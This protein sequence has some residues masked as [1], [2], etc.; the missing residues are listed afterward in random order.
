MWI[1][2][3]IES[4]LIIPQQYGGVFAT[5]TTIQM[6]N[7][8]SYRRT[9]N[10]A[11]SSCFSSGGLAGNPKQLDSAHILIPTSSFLFQLHQKSSVSRVFLSLESLKLPYN[12]IESSGWNFNE[13]L[14]KLYKPSFIYFAWQ[15]PF[16]KNLQVRLYL[17]LDFEGHSGPNTISPVRIHNNMCR[18]LWC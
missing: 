13:W 7:E 3:R 6:L 15:D 8:Y 16:E 18:R 17:V 4:V 1:K 11:N 5:S 10:K 14:Y 12:Y 9:Q 2:I